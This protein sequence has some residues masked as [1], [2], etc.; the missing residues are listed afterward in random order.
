MAGLIGKK[1][2]MTRI[3]KENVFIPVTLI[4]IPDNTVNQIKDIDKDGYSSIVLHSNVSSKK[5]K[6]KE[7]S[8][9]WY[10]SLKK[11]D[12]LSIEKLEKIESVEVVS[13]SKWKWFAWAMK[14]HNF[15][16]WPK[17]HGSKFHRALWSIWTRKPRKTKPWKK[18][19]GHMWNEQIKLKKISI[20][21]IDKDLKVIALKGWIPWAR[22]SVVI[23]NF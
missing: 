6:L 8:S 18:M 9:D 11:G 14:R 2:E 5:W 21:Y 13:F 3:I 7:V 22:N 23:L 16:G 17:T 10:E 12:I 20:E 15:H 1:L 19:H 4:E